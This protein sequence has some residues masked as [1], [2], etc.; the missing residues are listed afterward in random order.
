MSELDIVDLGA[1]R[2]ERG[3]ALWQGVTKVSE[4][5]DDTEPMGEGPVF[6]GLGLSSCPWPTDDS[7]KAEA[8]CVRSV[9]GRDTVYVGARDTRSSAIVGNL[10]PGDTV[11]HSTGPQQAAQLQL[12]EEKRQAA[13]VSKN[14]AG[15]TMVFL[16]DGD[17]D[18]A[19]IVLAGMIF[20][21]DAK[22]K[23]GVWSNGKASIILDGETIALD[24]LVVAG[25]TKPNPAAKFMVSPMVGP[26]P[27]PVAI[28]LPGAGVT[29]TMV[30]GAAKGIFP[31]LAILIA[32]TDWF[33]PNVQLRSPVPEHSRSGAIAAADSEAPDNQHRHRSSWHGSSVSS[34]SSSWSGFASDS[35]TPGHHGWYRPA[36]P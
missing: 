28:G 35:K 3:N 34:D 17:A 11:V 7:G 36:R 29:Y 19:Q 12:K 15:K 20:E 2:V 30:A 14:A 6:Q 24:G 33:S 5:D 10:K 23:T 27:T 1:T 4:E 22:K 13:L 31:A 9:A 18:K 25:G 21:M 16:L 26:S 8:V 32:F